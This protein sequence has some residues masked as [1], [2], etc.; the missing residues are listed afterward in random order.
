M[1]DKLLIRRER[2]AEDEAV[3]FT[4]GTRKGVVDVPE[5]EI[6]S[7][8]WRAVMENVYEHFMKQP[9]R[10]TSE[11]TTEPKGG[12]IHQKGQA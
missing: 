11:Q 3:R 5:S 4:S 8:G 12:V 6:V 2:I 1:Q 7:I 9:E 10:A